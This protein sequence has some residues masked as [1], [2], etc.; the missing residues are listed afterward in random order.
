REA[1]ARKKARAK[2]DKYVKK[3]KDALKAKRY[4]EAAQQFTLADKLVPN[5]SYTRGLLR[6][7]QDGLARDAD[8][9]RRKQEAEAKLAREKALK[10]ARKEADDLVKKGRKA[11]K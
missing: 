3:G 1:E 6:Q 9:L 10:A 2:A 7:A 8:R 11:L 4:A 5:D